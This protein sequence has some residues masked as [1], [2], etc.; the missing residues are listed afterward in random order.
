[1]KPILR[2]TLL[3]ALLLTVFAF[4]SSA[5]VVIEEG[6]TCTVQCSNGRTGT[7]QASSGVGCFDLCFFA[8][9]IAGQGVSTCEYTH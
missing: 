9:G 2:M 3:V 7:W 1:M 5:D 4:G 8:C 6:G